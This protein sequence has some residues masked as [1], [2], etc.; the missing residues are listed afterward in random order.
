MVKEKIAENA[1]LESLG[2]CWVRFIDGEGK[3]KEFLLKKGDRILIKI[4]AILRAGNAQALVVHLG[5]NTYK[6]L[7]GSGEVINL[8]M[9]TSGLRKVKDVPDTL[10]KPFPR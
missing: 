9:D 4:P 10:K 1:T 8:L 5:N 2:S 6:N 3:L 7:G